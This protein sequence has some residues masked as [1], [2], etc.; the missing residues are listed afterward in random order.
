MPRKPRLFIPDA[1]VHVI[2]RG[3]NRSAI[4]RDDVDRAVFITLLRRTAKRHRLPIHGYALMD[5][6]YHV[7]VTP[8]DAGCLP[9]AMKEFGGRY[10]RYFNRRYERIGTLWNGRYRSL[11]IHDERYWLTCLRYIEQNP[12]RAQM[13]TRPSE[14]HW[15]SYRFHALGAKEDWLTPHGLYLALGTTAH[16]RQLAYRAMC[17]VS[18]S[19]TELVEQRS[20]WRPLGVVGDSPSRRA[21]SDSEPSSG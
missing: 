2:H 5:T 1:S 21:A 14:F 6:H 15:S 19:E 16:E 3:N 7:M 4:V 10:V 12:V 8:P 11:L 17:D 9:A 20:M 18:I 13:V